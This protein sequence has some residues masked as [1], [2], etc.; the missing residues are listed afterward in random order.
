MTMFEEIVTTRS[1]MSV[2]FGRI[3]N[4]EVQHAHD[5]NLSR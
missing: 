5:R 4:R 1:D 3:E 2:P